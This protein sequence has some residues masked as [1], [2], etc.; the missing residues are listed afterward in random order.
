[1]SSNPKVH[2]E[3][4]GNGWVVGAATCNPTVCNP[5]GWVIDYSDL[6]A[7]A[8]HVAVELDD[9][10]FSVVIVSRSNLRPGWADDLIQGNN[11]SFLM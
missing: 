7:T 10:C 4:S 8:D 5:Q 1:M 6:S 9:N 11:P 2:T 3:K